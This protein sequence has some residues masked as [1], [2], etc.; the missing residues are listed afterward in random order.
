M[1]SGSEKGSVAA[2]PAPAFNR[3]FT[4]LAAALILAFFARVLTESQIKSPVADEPPHIASGLS[5]VSTG[6]FR[7]NPQHPPLLKELSGLSMRL[8]G[9]QWPDNPDTRHFLFGSLAPGEQPDWSIGRNLIIANGPDRVLF[10]A[11]LPLILIATMLAALIYFWGRELI[12]DLAALC[13]LLLFTCDPN[14]VAHSY[15]VTMDVG[16]TA[17]SVLFLC[18]LW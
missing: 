8:D 5:Y 16:V 9:I 7:G 11:R 17:F 1:T 4:L 18:T 14:I 2:T 6:I 13:A 15:T 12:G 3:V 10:W